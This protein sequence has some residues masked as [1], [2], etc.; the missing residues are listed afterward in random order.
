M[1]LPSPKRVVISGLLAAL[2]VVGVALPAS[3]AAAPLG[4]IE[5]FP[6]AQARAI[7]AGPDGNLWFT[8]Q[9]GRIGRVTPGGAITEFGEADGLNPG[10]IPNAIVP[11]PDGNLWFTDVGPTKA[12]GRITP[13]GAITEFSAGLPVSTFPLAIAAGSDGNLWFTD[14]R[15]RNEEQKITF[16]GVVTGDKFTLTFN[17]ITTSEITFSSTASTLRNN[18]KNALTAALGPNFAIAGTSAGINVTFTGT[19]GHADVPLLVCV[20]KTG[21]GSCSVSEITPGSDNAIGRITPAGAITEFSAGLNPGNSPLEI[22]SGADGNLWFTDQ[23]TSSA[24]GRITPA[25]A[26][27]EF[28]SGLNPGS[29]PGGNSA[30]A[31]YGIAPGPDGNVWFLDNG[32]TKAIGRVSPSGAITEFSGLS[33]SSSGVLS[34]ASGADGNLWFTDLSGVAEQQTVTVEGAPTGGTFKLTFKGQSTGATGTGDLTN[35]S[36]TVSSVVT[37]T[38][39]FVAGEAVSGIGIPAGTTITTVGAGTLTLSNAASATGTGIAFSADLSYSVGEGGVLSAE[40]LRLALEALPAIGANNI[41]VSESNTVTFKNAL[42]LTDVP[43][44]TCDGSGLTGGTSPACSVATV[45]AG[46]PNQFGR[47]TTAGAISEF[48]ARNATIPASVSPGS[49]GNLWFTDAAEPNAIGWLGLGTPSASLRT[50]SVSGT[51]QVGTQQVCSGDRWASWA[52]LQPED[53]GL[54]SSSTSPSAVQWFVEGAPV[55]TAATYAPVSGDVGKPLT[56]KR[57]V[58]Y[59]SPLFVTAS[60]TS[61]PVNVIVQNSGPTGP[62][63]PAGPAGPTGPTGATGATGNDGID[64]ANGASG[65]AGPAGAKGEQGPQGLAGRDAKVICTVKKKGAKVKVTCKVQLVASASGLLLGWRLMRSGRTYTQ[66]SV[67]VRHSHASISLDLS[68]LDRG[69]YTLRLRGG[70]TGTT[71]DIG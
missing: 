62:T 34:I 25:G 39:A 44:M 40:V 37:S 67:R 58:T 26:I 27:T 60:A 50:P 20:V 17:E 29:S 12:I 59:R 63:G 23:G 5:E 46:A 11:G 4:S 47:I 14:R 15:A 6:S 48:N 31:P 36:S 38:G 61:E 57:T 43:Q 54:L 1:F 28:S 19:F 45:Q 41:D 10:G 51:A 22:A 9:Q 30:F 71:I 55:G 13:S 68:R 42:G 21:T 53:G 32:T 64:G 33:A 2:I 8:Q 69:R 7:V 52:G 65:P 49:D 18:I 16:P 56:C 35:G 66:G 70:R 24:I 3:G